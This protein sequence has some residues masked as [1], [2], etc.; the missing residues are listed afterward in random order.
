MGFTESE[1]YLH[2]H[3]NY[4]ANANR[5]DRAISERRTGLRPMTVF[6]HANLRDEQVMR[7][8]F[9]RVARLP[10]VRERHPP[11]TRAASFEGPICWLLAVSTVRNCQRLWTGSP[12]AG[13]HG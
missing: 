10:P 4:F 13:G 12:A 6:L 3:A 8:Q 1:D 5:L 2:F 11:H 7:E 9:A